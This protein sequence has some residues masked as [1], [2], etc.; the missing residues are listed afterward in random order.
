M[1]AHSR[2][3]LLSAAEGERRPEATVASEVD[4]RRLV[5]ICGVG[6][7]GTSLL[8]SML[9][10]HPE[11]AFPPET[12][13]FRRYVAPS[14]V[15]KALE[16]GTVASFAARLDADVDFARANIAAE[17]LLAGQKDG[18][19]APLAVFERLL[20]LYSAGQGKHRVGD[21]DPR[22]LDHLPALARAFP[23]AYVLHVIRD[24][25]DV[26]L[27]RTRAAWSKGRPWWQ[28][29]LLAQDQLR[30]GRQLGARLFG[31]RYLE[32][33]YEALVAEPEQ[34]LAAV[35]AH[36]GLDYDAAMLQFGNSARAL[37]DSREHSWKKETLGPLLTD[38]VEKWRRELP[39][40]QI[41]FV[42]RVSSEAFD[43]LGYRRSA[44]ASASGAGP[45]PRT[46]SLA[47]LYRTMS[48]SVFAARRLLE[49]LR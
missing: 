31:A 23:S 19:L 38:N 37:V 44:G 42:E 18:A 41:A 28:H 4:V 26:L 27:S 9:N 45:A 24:P 40:A 6:R 43:R 48:R 17:A 34:T 25:R 11:L 20:A 39:A 5:L 29:V 2:G 30:R 33:R 10:A 12:H 15:R 46:P 13:F 7:S 8:H 16:R 47:P 1:G 21:K 14:R 22:N 32:V 3:S 35:A 36:I 49:G